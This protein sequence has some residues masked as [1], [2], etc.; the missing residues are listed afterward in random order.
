MNPACGG[1]ITW[2]M[3]SNRVCHSISHVAE[4]ARP[5]HTEVCVHGDPRG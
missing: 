5:L 4:H 2:Q 3:G 1:Y